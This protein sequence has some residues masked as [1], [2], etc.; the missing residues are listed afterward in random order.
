M[1]G[2]GG[3]GAGGE[4]VEKDIVDEMRVGRE[5]LR[6]RWGMMRWR[7]GG[8]CGICVLGERRLG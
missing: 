6:M 1:E 8:K 7:K 3:L 5:R 4:E 2:E